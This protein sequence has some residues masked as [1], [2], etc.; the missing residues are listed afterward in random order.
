VKRFA[1]L[2]AGGAFWLFLAALPAL[3]DG[4]PH[5]MAQNSGSTTLTAD[6][7]ASCHRAH[8]AKGL[9]L[10]NDAA[11]DVSINAYCT[12][13]HGASGT[14]ATT[15]V[16]T[17]VQ[18]RTGTANVRGDVHLGVLR[19]GGFAEARI[20]S[21]N[22]VRA[23]YWNT[24]RGETSFVAK[25][26]VKAAT[27]VTS[28]HIALPGVAGLEPQ[29]KI[30][31]GYNGTVDNP[32]VTLECIS[33]HNPHG[34]GQYRILRPVPVA[35]TYTPTNAAATTSVADD[36]A[37]LAA[38]VSPGTD[39]RNYTIIQYN[40]A[41]TGRFLLASQVQAG[42]FS[43]SAGDYF[44]RKVPWTS[45]ASSGTNTVWDGPNGDSANFN[46]QI[47]AWCIQCHT[48]YLSTGWSVNTGD[49]VFT[50]RHSQ[51][52]NKSCLT[53]HVA[54]G[55]NAVMD[56]VT[57]GNFPYPDAVKTNSSRLLK[58]DNR[59]TCQVCHEPTG[60]VIATTTTPGAPNPYTGTWPSPVL[61]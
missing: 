25:V 46:P 38:V 4:G 59:G 5:A 41:T 51:S 2:L 55:S 19:G 42:A 60:T 30:W 22:A 48:R 50:Y 28:A 31:G 45:T 32:V 56:G 53:C 18:W 47:N 58:V 29:N 54:H 44:H 23:S 27:P 43:T 40:P 61:P 34:N 57:S 36:A 17:G 20:D 24:S 10:L 11:A 6:G 26:G 37:N 3:A 8:T 35:D 9:Y 13:C 15:D 7:C 33:C 21:S 14:G 1:L 52:N 49:P 12:T 16:M 39:T